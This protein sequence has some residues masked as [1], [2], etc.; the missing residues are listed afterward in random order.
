MKI[1]LNGETVAVEA[2]ALPEILAELG[3]GDARVATAVNESFVAAGARDGVR[4]EP[5]DRLEVVAPKQ[6]G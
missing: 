2:T 5:G 3:Y 6:G 1:V 4:L